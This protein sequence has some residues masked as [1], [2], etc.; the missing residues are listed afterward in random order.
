MPAIRMHLHKAIPIGGGL[1]GGSSNGAFTLMLLNEELK[2]NIAYEKLVN[3]ALKLGSDCPFFILNKP[4]H[5]TGRGEIMQ[6]VVIDLTAYYFVLAHPAIHVST[7]EAFRQL[8][9]PDIQ[10]G[11][12]PLTEIIR[13]PVESWKELLINEFEAPMFKRYPLLAEIKDRFYDAGAEYA[14]MTGT[15]SCIYGIFARNKKRG[16]LEAGEQYK[17][18]TLNQSH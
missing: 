12:Y 5:A 8:D 4:C 14:S 11:N 2:L 15:G 9:R 1:G 10:Q 3:Y 16:N 6:E 18:Y 17:V 13:Q 7:A